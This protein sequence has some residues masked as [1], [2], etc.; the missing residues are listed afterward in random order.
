MW[1][2]TKGHNDGAALEM[3]LEMEKCDSRVNAH[4][5]KRLRQSQASVD[6]VSCIIGA[7]FGGR[8]TLPFEGTSG[9]SPTFMNICALS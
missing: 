4:L 5:P 1:D 2:A 3:L 6:H 9:K 7:G 8:E